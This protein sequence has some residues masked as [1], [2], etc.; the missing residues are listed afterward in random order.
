NNKLDPLFEAAAQAVEEAII[1]AMVAAESMVGR[2]D[3]FVAA[4]DHDALRKLMRTY[5]RLNG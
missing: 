4:I 1:N 2:E 5:G 3:R